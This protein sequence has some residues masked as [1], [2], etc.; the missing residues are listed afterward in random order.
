MSFLLRLYAVLV[1]FSAVLVGALAL[2]V[3]TGWF[4]AAPV[5]LVVAIPPTVLH[6]VPW[7]AGTR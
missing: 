3:V 2:P 6:L 7:V 5:A 4:W 1:V